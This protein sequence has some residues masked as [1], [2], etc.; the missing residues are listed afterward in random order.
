MDTL[1]TGINNDILKICTN[2]F[3]LYISGN[4]E[5]KKF[6]A[7]NNNKNIEATLDV[8]S[9]YD[10]LEVYSINSAKQLDINTS[11]FMYPSFFE[12]GSYDIYLENETDDIFEIYHCDK[13]IRDNL[14][15]RRNNITGS[16]KFNGEVG[17]S[18][19]KVRKN[20]KEV[21]S[22]TIQ[23]FPTKLDYMDDYNEILSEINEEINSL[24]FDFISKTFS[25]VDIKDV[26]KQTNL[27]YIVILNNIFEKLEKAINRTERY[28]KHGVL[29]EYNIKNKHKC[30]KV[31][32]KESIKH[33]RKNQKSQNLVEVKKNTTIDIFENQYVKY[34]IKRI[35][36]KIVSVKSEVLKKKGNDNIYYKKLSFIESKLI[37]HL[38]TFYKDI[39]DLSGNKSM[40]LAF[41]MASGYK[42]VYYHY[43]LLSKGLDICT[44]IYDISHKKLYELYEIW[45]Y[46]KIHNIIRDLGYKKNQS[47]IIQTNSNGLILSLAYNKGAKCIYENDGGEKIELWYNKS[48]SSPTTN[49]RPDT[50]LCLNS[51]RVKDRVY[52]FD[53]KYRLSVNSDGSI[54]PMEDDI[55][56]MHRYRDSIV[57]EIKS[58]NHFR[59]ETVGAYVMFPCSDEETFKNNKYYK[60]IEKVNIG[61]IPMLPG[62]TSLMKKHICKIINESYV[63]AINNNPVFDEEDD[64]YKFKNKNVMIV[65]VKDRVH[66]EKYKG[67]CFY[68]IPKKSLSK[69]RLGIEYLAFY[70][71]KSQFKEDSGIY[72]FAKIKNIYEYERIDCNELECNGGNDNEI[73]IRFDLED[74]IYIDCIKSVEYGPVTVNY[75]TMYLLKNATTMHEL[76]MKNRREIE[77]YKIL[78]KSSKDKGLNLRKEKDGFYLGEKHIRLYKDNKIKVNNEITDINNA[79]NLI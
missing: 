40:T 66:F 55:N 3:S 34:I 12:D 9:I 69:V 73:Y 49:Q 58:N 26:E 59:Y 29:N 62:S 38:N 6:K 24:I 13:N 36:K 21:L 47:P 51:D 70:Q 32:T 67:H 54:E 44:G 33:L 43:L 11:Q 52:I 48:Y 65:N 22:F 50:V 27:E 56:V 20:N 64:Y 77:L 71:P 41:K 16:F 5:N 76:Y 1:V 28:P 53:S 79:Y 23:V 74:F 68:H 37:K 61:A 4:S 18:T 31:S 10:D 39:S 78:K 17:Y 15:Y 63:E 46:I 75:T 72:Y 60:S 19:F 14:R 57:S 35:V 30:K 25:S 2:E 7:T 45:C 8:E 42:E